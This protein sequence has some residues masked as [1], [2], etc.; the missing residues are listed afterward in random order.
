MNGCTAIKEDYQYGK[1]RGGFGINGTGHALP[2]TGFNQ[3]LQ[4][5]A[6]AVQFK[7]F[8]DTVENNNRAVDGKPTTVK[9]AATN[10]E[11]SSIWKKEK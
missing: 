2:D 9:S 1:Q 5:F 7:V 11:S 8:T 4:P 10:E 6:A 3:L